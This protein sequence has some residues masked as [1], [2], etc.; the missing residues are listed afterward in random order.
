MV[1]FKSKIPSLNS[2]VVFSKRLMKE[3]DDIM[4]Y[5]I[6]MVMAPSGYG[7]TTTVAQW[8]KQKDIYVSWVT[9]QEEDNDTKF[10]WMHVIL[11]LKNI[12]PNIDTKV[13]LSDNNFWD[14]LISNIL[15]D[16]CT[17]SKQ[18]VLVLDDYNFIKERK[19]HKSLRLFIQ[20]LPKNIHIILI[21]LSKPPWLIPISSIKEITIRDLK[22][23]ND[24][25]ED[26]LKL[27]QLDLELKD[28]DEIIFQTEGWIAGLQIVVFHLKQNKVDLPNHKKIRDSYNYIFEYFNQK[29]NNK[30]PEDIIDF[31]LKTSILDKLNISLCNTVTERVDS[32]KILKKLCN[33]GI[34]IIPL[35]QG[36]G[37]YRY[38]HLLLKFLRNKVKKKYGANIYSLYNL[39]GEWYKEKGFYANAIRMFS[40]S[41]S[42]EKSISIIQKH[43]AEIL[44]DENPGALLK[45]LKDIPEEKMET[46][47]F[48][49]LF[50]AWVLALT[51]NKKESEECVKK[52]EE[53]CCENS[54]YLTEQDQKNLKGEIALLR[55]KI[56]AYDFKKMAHYYNEYYQLITR[57]S[58][59]IGQG[60]KF[61]NAY[62]MLLRVKYL[63][64]PGNLKQIEMKANKMQKTI[65]ESGI[66]ILAGWNYALSGEI[67]YELND[68]D[69]ATQQLIR[70]INNADKAE[71]TGM[72]IPSIITLAKVRRAQGDF[73]CALELIS[74]AE[75]KAYD[76]NDL[77]WIEKIKAFKIILLLEKEDRKPDNYWI[78]N[79][80]FSILEKLSID[81]EL[82]HIVLVRVLL[83]RG[84]I[85]R[86]MLSLKRLL[87]FVEE[88]KIYLSIIEVLNLLAIAYYQ[89][90]QKRKA[91]KTL[92]KSLIIGEKDRLLRCY[93]DEGKPMAILLDDFIK[94]QKEKNKESKVPLQYVQKLLKLTQEYASRGNENLLSESF[95]TRELEIL[96]NLKK[97]LS[98]NEISEELYIALPTVKWHLRNIYRKLRVKNRTQAVNK[99][100]EY[101]L[102]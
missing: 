39:A 52:A 74:E 34:Y 99:A 76:Y 60:V 48:L 61:N 21:S 16:I 12:F 56:N 15:D 62:R 73:D 13:R 14:I 28:K 88:E 22:F 69:K 36:I 83:D 26:F 92:E 32:D 68:L 9:L 101:N 6:A 54:N 10:F 50:N 45:L 38:H 86:A 80:Y 24:E 95:T 33:L 25:A 53:F 3:L 65:K 58:L 71:E 91:L 27:Q 46:S 100:M 5:K 51:Y 75:K 29:L 89:M 43:G 42:Y 72:L 7:K 11:S 78:E 23:N 67:A 2:N 20:Y 4:N 1:E 102:T 49:C 41:K 98:N 84:K 18:I 8:V 82:E 63:Y 19:V 17:S 70:G 90:G 77:N 59:I 81:N 94:L 37:S 31:L 85:D 35:N 64:Y 93:I 87:I 57:G 96:C 55:V 40:Q 79:H 44:R 66:D 97:G 30:L 47:P